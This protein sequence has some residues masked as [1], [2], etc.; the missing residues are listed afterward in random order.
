MHYDVLVV[1]SG[2]AGM[3]SALKLGDM[4]YSVLVV[5][6]EASVGGRMILLSKVFPTLD[7]ASCIS[8]PKMAATIHH[9]NLTVKTYAEVEGI[10][11]DGKGGFHATI[12]QKPRFVAMDACTGCQ[13]CEMACTVAVPD[14]F[15]SDL[16]ARRAAYIPFPQAVPKKAV[17]DHPGSSPCTF[18]CPAG[19]KAHGYVSLVRSGEYEKAFNLILETTP[20]AGSLGRACMAPCEAQCSR[21][22]LEGPVPIR[23]LKRFV[24]D[25]HYGSG[26]SPGIAPTPARSQRVAVVGSG[27]AGLTAAWQLAKE[28]YRVK[29]FEQA[30]VPG[31]ALALAIPA[32]RLPQDVV[33]DDVANVTALGVEI[34]TGHR[35]EDL[36]ALHRDFD[37]ILVATGTPA[38]LHL[39]VPGE[40]LPQAIGALEFL[41]ACKLGSPPDLRG[42]DVVVVGGGNVAIDSARSVVRLGARTV[43]EV[44]L[45]RRGE[46]PA[47]SWEVEE[48]LTEG[49]ELHDGW[50]I[51]AILGDGEVT[52]IR[53]K[54]CTAVFD[55]TG[56]FNPQYD[57]T[58]T[59]VLPCQVVVVAVGMRADTEAFGQLVT[60]NRNRTVHVDPKTLQTDIPYVFAAG[61][62]TTGATIIAQ[63]V[64]SGRRAATMI[65]RYL[66]GLPFAPE[67]FDMRLPRVEP[68]DVLSRQR[69][70]TPRPPLGAP[71]RLVARPRDFAEVEPP[72]SEAEALGSTARC[73]DCGV[74]SEC[75][76]CVHTC[77]ADA[78]HLDQREEKIEVDVGSVILSTGFRLFAADLK[79]Q[80]GYGRF[81]NVITGMQ[82]DRLLAPTRPY[83]TV[84]RPGD[85]RV[86][87]RIAY[88]MCTGS[89]DQSVGNPLCSKICCMYSVKQNQLIMGALPLADVTVFYVDMRTAGKGYDEFFVQSEAMGTTYIK[90]RIGEITEKDSGDLIVR[91]EDIEHGGALQEAE[92]DLVV[93]AVGIQPNP[94]VAALFAG[95]SPA[96]DPFFYVQ[97]IDEE[98]SPG[99]TS[100]AGVFAAGTATGAKDIPDTILHSGAAA[101]QAAAYVERT[102][103]HA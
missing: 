54:R 56:R 64:G 40:D 25:T 42:K 2:I 87:S 103:V 52:G 41:R 96:L 60:L 1:G 91:Y 51:A 97:E 37:A 82:M 66:R 90:A 47:S 32:Y 77:P 49:V 100:L 80:Y 45:E 46:M 84:L 62:V 50:G 70:Y 8:T 16:V 69:G 99:Q 76:E 101:A 81:A 9:P 15:N 44:C 94:E 31:G 11:A 20:L 61:D 38:E 36:Q 102:K 89:R 73:L 21:G 75:Q 4:G 27:P 14:A 29:I 5:E 85:G 79:P 34:E 26:R 74:C 17:I 33:A 78:I 67:R 13:Q 95:E 86:P 10:R 72:L 3:E 92:F 35:V 24:A 71:R 43:S 28:G 7:C 63:A 58:E 55:A 68:Q 98:L 83:N 53:L 19:I 22:Q 93:L 18:T 65:D 59:K 6:K 23:R 48:A 39:G 57:E 12:R 88:V 30:P